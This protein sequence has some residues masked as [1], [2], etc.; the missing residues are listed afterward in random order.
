MT[1]CRP[2]SHDRFRPPDASYRTN[3]LATTEASAVPTRDDWFATLAIIPRRP[4]TRGTTEAGPT[5]RI[6]FCLLVAD[7]GSVS[8]ALLESSSVVV[9]TS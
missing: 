3:V 2:V 4:R 7:L 5:R 1:G 9:A 8:I 6:R